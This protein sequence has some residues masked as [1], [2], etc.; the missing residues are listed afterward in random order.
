VAVSQKGGGD[1]GDSNGNGGPSQP[2]LNVSSITVSNTIGLQS[3]SILTFNPIYNGAGRGPVTFQWDFAD[4]T[5]GTGAPVSHVFQVS[6]TF[7]VR[8][9]G[10]D[11]T[12]SSSAQTTVT[13]R[14]VTGRWAG[15]VVC[16]AGRCPPPGRFPI[17]IDA[18]QTGTNVSGTTRQQVPGFPPDTCTFTGGRVEEFSIVAFAP[19]QGCAVLN[20]FL[21][22]VGFLDQ[23]T[24]NVFMPGPGVNGH[25][26]LT[27]Q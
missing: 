6:G 26:E 17:T 25:C 21:G 1:D 8:V 18:T 9:T 15:E 27:R 2:P 20:L 13:I 7:A 19:F 3:A 24:L 11:G 16:P 5:T 22:C 14:N 23:A 10:N 12:T 4:G